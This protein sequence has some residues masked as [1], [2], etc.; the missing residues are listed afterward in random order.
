MSSL[1]SQYSAGFW[2]QL[3]FLVLL[4][5][6]I[7]APPHVGSARA[8]T[9]TVKVGNISEPEDASYFRIYY[10]QSFKVIKNSL[11]AKSYLLIQNN[12][13]MATR[14]KYCTSRIK[15]FVIP[16]ANYSIQSDYY[17]PVSFFEVRISML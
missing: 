8:A 13:R 4:Y 15:S 17:F 10:G 11:D 5:C 14:T 3:L 12:T 2:A 7:G 1:S 9:P 6:G 16:L